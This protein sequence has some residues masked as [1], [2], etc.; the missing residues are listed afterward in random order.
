MDVDTR[1]EI[2]MRTVTHLS[3]GLGNNAF[4]RVITAATIASPSPDGL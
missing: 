1:D 3:S 4:R 2:H